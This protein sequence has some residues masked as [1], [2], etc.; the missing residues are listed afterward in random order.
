MFDFMPPFN[1]NTANEANVFEHQNFHNG[2][3]YRELCLFPI[4]KAKWSSAIAHKIPTRYVPIASTERIKPQEPGKNTQRQTYSRE[5][6]LF[7]NLSRNE[8]DQRD[9][10]RS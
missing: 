2:Q 10:D 6:K 7:C 1:F 3:F 4:V 8:V 9:R 5:W